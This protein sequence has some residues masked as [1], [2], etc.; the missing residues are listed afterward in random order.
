MG[1]GGARWGWVVVAMSDGAEVAADEPPP[2]AVSNVEAAV[3]G[4][5]VAAGAGEVVAGGALGTNPKFSGAE[6]DA[7]ETPPPA[8]G[9][10]A[11]GTSGSL[12]VLTLD[13]SARIPFATEHPLQGCSSPVSSIPGCL[14]V[15]RKMLEWPCERETWKSL[16]SCVP[17]VFLR[18]NGF[19]LVAELPPLNRRR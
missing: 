17:F 6:V 12:V 13:V 18:K 1:S 2:P 19:C 4:G 14:A 16:I 7:D 3:V 5:R 8:A 15:R 11:A 10:G 9:E